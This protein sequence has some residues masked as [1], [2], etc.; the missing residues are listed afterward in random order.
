MAVNNT[1][2]RFGVD[3][4]N[5]LALATIATLND[6]MTGT[7]GATWENAYALPAGT[8]SSLSTILTESDAVTALDREYQFNLNPDH[9]VALETN[10]SGEYVNCADQYLDDWSDLFRVLLKDGSPTGPRANEPV[11]IDYLQIGSEPTSA[12]NWE[13]S[14]EA[15]IGFAEMVKLA[16]AAIKV[17][18]GV[19][20]TKT[21]ASGHNFGNRFMFLD[22]TPSDLQEWVTHFLEAVNGQFDIFSLHLNHSY[23]GIKR[24]VSWVRSQLDA[25]KATAN[26]PIWAEDMAHGPFYISPWATTAEIDYFTL[27][28]AGDSATVLDYASRQAGY[29]IKK[30]SVAF[31]AG[32]ERIM[33]S[34]DVNRDGYPEQQYRYMGLLVATNPAPYPAGTKKPSFYSYKMAIE[35]LDGFVSCTE[36]Q[37]MARESEP[38]GV[39]SGKAAYKYTFRGGRPKVVAWLEGGDE[40]VI[41]LSGVFRGGKVTVKTPTTVLNA[42]HLPILVDE[43]D[44]PSC[45]V[46]ITEVPVF[47]SAA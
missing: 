27:L 44:C 9:S 4:A 30:I 10:G 17:H 43:F 11:P 14:R 1:I 34:Q 36:L 29:L 35:E 26:K 5:N 15:A 13:M 46:P 16:H 2:R 41:D 8:Y 38:P 23:A 22:D 24:L 7:N 47:V 28:K 42:S 32:V 31:A 45:R 40:D 25:E 21:M 6:G 39:M 37:S 12:G 18:G 3:G 19:H 33:I 20:G